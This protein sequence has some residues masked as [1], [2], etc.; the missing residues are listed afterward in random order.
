MNASWEAFLGIL[1]LA[2]SSFWAILLSYIALRRG[3]AVILPWTI[4]GF[5][6]L[7]SLGLI[8]LP[9]LNLNLPYLG[10]VYVV[11]E[12]LSAKNLSIYLRHIVAHLLVQGE[13]IAFLLLALYVIPKRVR[14]AREG[15][16]LRLHLNLIG[17]A[18]VVF[19]FLLG[20]AFYL[21]YFF[22]GP[23]LA[24]LSQAR[25]S[26][27]SPEEA[28]TARSLAWSQVETGQGSFGASIAAYTIFPFFTALIALL[29]EGKNRA[30]LFL[31]GG[32]L[33]LLSAAYALQT[34]QKAPLAY[35]ALMYGAIFVLS[36]QHKSAIFVTNRKRERTQSI[37]TIFF[38]VLGIILGVGLYATNFGLSLVDSFVSFLGRLLLVP[39]NTEGFWFLVYPEAHNFLGVWY[40]FNTNMEIIRMT[41]YL[42]TGDVF[43]ANASFV[44]VGWS[45]MGFWGVLLSGAL[46][47]IYLI[48]VEF[49]AQKAPPQVKRMATFAS[50]PPLFFLVSGTFFDFTLKGGVVPLL[51]LIA[52]SAK[53]AKSTLSLPGSLRGNT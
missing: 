3:W 8:F 39:P 18:L 5:V 15:F 40:A 17:K 51:L 23:G 35:V 20:A 53:R 13:L 11:Y 32:P 25:L 28:V 24:L 7:D 2:T 30:V 31:L 52:V 44:A 26:F 50:L 43:S 38:A 34:Y 14:I 36:M 16:Q 49:L 9:F 6:V 1:T 33:F 22:S 48:L 42:A 19:A 37:Y 29:T 4:I 41:A 27:S 21:K 46:V 45:G 10:E 12:G 47:A